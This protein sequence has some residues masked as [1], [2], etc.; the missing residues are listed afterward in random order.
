MRMNQRQIGGILVAAA[1]VIILFVQ[2]MKAREDRLI[3]AY[4][5]E[6][7]TCYLSDGTC[8]HADRDYAP[9]I[10]GWVLGGALLLLGAY[11]AFFDKTQ[12]TLAAHQR[13]VSSALKE[14][15]RKDH[16]NAFLEGFSED[17]RK[18]L[19]AVR[20]QDGIKQSTLRYRTG[21]SKASLSLILKGLEARGVLSRK[22]S[23]KTKNVFL[24]KRF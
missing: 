17:E 15:T 20:G 7:G 5:A 6:E 21:I 1:L 10:F 3:D 4:V 14:A 8:L 19:V 9:I 24:K 13:E 2:V 22:E 23:G 12:E 16:F 18:V 11:L